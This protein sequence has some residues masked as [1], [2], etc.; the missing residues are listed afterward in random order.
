MPKGRP[1]LAGP[2]QAVRAARKAAAHALEALRRE[3]LSMRARLEEL[4]GE[5]KSF[6]ADLFPSASARARRRGRPAKRPGRVQKRVRSHRGPAKADRFFAELPQRFTLEAV[7]EVAGRLSGVS[8][9][10]WTR[11]R[12]ITKT[13]TGYVKT[14]MAS[15]A[16][17]ISKTAGDARAKNGGES[18]SVRK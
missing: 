16:K 13:A 7:R 18:R 9:A 14:T 6:L 1:R 10:Q 5:E 15:A 11:A 2:L 8:L 4:V 12:R 3:I 17:S